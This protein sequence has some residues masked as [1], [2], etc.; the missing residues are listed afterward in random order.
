MQVNGIRHEC[1][2]ILCQS[3]GFIHPFSFRFF[4]WCNI[5]ILCRVCFGPQTPWNSFR[6]LQL[7]SVE[8]VGVSGNHLAPECY[9]EING[10]EKKELLHITFRSWN[11]DNWV[12]SNPISESK[13]TT[14]RGSLW[15]C[16]QSLSLHFSPMI[17]DFVLGQI[18]IL[19]F[20]NV[21]QVFF[22][23]EKIKNIIDHLIKRSFRPSSSTFTNIFLRGFD[24]DYILYFGISSATH[25]NNSWSVWQLRTARLL[26]CSVVWARTLVDKIH[27]K[28]TAISEFENKAW[29]A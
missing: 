5:L 18:K 13:H 19:F 10:H 23:W 16:F 8:N 6:R 29:E 11:Y 26:N 17:L 4:L 3:V 7:K 27:H 12:R 1:A 14:I 21:N 22:Y 28:Q 15:F 24:S 20:F 25:Y 2:P 9:Y